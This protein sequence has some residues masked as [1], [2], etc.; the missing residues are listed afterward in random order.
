[1]DYPPY[2]YPSRGGRPPVN[3]TDRSWTQGGVEYNE[4]TTSYAS[5]GFVFEMSSTTSHGGGRSR[6]SEG[7]SLFGAAVGLLGDVFAAR[8]AAQQDRGGRGGRRDGEDMAYGGGVHEEGSSRRKSRGILGSMAEKLLN[9]QQ[10]RQSERRGQ[11]GRER[12]ASRAR[13]YGR[14]RM[15][16]REERRDSHTSRKSAYT[17]ETSDEESNEYDSDD[18]DLP[19][20]RQPRRAF[21]ADDASLIQEL[22]DN[23][24]RHRR[25]MKRCQ[26]QLDAA[27]RAPYVRSSVVRG[28]ENEMRIHESA[29]LDAVDNLRRAK[30]GARNKWTRQ[31]T[32]DHPRRR[33]GP[34]RESS[35]ET[36]VDDDFEHFAQPRR[37]TSASYV[38]VD[39]FDPFGYPFAAFENIFHGLGGGFSRTHPLHEAFFGMP[40]ASSTFGPEPNTRPRASRNTRQ[41]SYPFSSFHQHPPP[42]APPSTLLTPEEA[43]RLFKPYNDRWLSLSPTDP[44]IPYPT[45]T[46]SPSAL[47]SR[48][49][50]YAQNLSSPISTWSDELVMQANTQAFF[51]GA[52]GLAPS[53]TDSGPTGQ[54]VLGFDRKTAGAERVR[55]LIE[56]LKKEKGRW[57]SDRLGRR[58][59]GGQGANEGLAGDARARAVFH[60]VCELMTF[61]LGG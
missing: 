48:S 60:G 43:K 39:G 36:Y 35:F 58:N 50:L 32:S 3:R 54:V 24:E 20:R 19:R 57:H 38:R 5:P 14:S 23:V 18:S 2:S 41:H 16:R 37:N 59:G 27:S 31:R 56:M 52:A 55:Q 12:E 7:P 22:E 40:H 29:H 11:R 21:T 25:E 1:M 6:R 15:D 47:A 17:D 46:L 28:L 4:E 10:G 42:P 26:K 9:G 33:E 13:G 49:T 44:N 34:S 30:E 61:A 8:Q 51:L 53:Y 45:R